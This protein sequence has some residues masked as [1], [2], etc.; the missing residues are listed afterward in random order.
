MEKLFNILRLYRTPNIGPVGF[1]YL[2]N[3]FGSAEVA[4][5]NL[6]S[7]AQKWRGKEIILEAEE[8]INEEIEKTTKFGAKFITIEDDEYPIPLRG[9]V[10]NPP[11]LIVL[12]NQKLFNERIISIVGSRNASL[13]GVKF[14]RELTKNLLES[15][16]VTCSGMAIGIDSAVH[17]MDP[18]RTIAVLAGGIDSVYPP[19]NQTLYEQI[20][21]KGLIISDRA[22]GTEASQHLFPKRNSI[23]AAL[24]VAT[25]LIESTKDSGALITAK[26]AFE[27]GRT[28]FA[29]PG[30]PYDPRY[31]GNNNAIKKGAKVLLDATDIISCDSLILREDI[32]EIHEDPNERD[33]RI[34]QALLSYSPTSIGLLIKESGLSTSKVIAIIS[35]MEIAGLV[36]TE[37]I[38]VYKIS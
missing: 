3:K 32:I 35:E 2:L 30:H 19:I 34:V 7:I 1:K 18:S 13:N 10:N 12:G 9:I 8:K 11:V 37:S 33:I 25:C 16:F 26:C 36:K 15:D 6:G 31:E 38:F 23:I 28:V 17:R 14:A 27:Y 4:I 20:K 29:V 22:F 21:E 5:K 24:G